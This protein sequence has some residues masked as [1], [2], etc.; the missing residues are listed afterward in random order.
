MKLWD[1]GF[2]TAEFVN[3]FTVGKDREMDLYLAQYDALGCMA[4]AQMLS[5]CG[6]L[7]KEDN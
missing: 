1:K 4:H 6:L 5:E 7:S 3:R 2:D